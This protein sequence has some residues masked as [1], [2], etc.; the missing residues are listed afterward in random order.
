MREMIR[1][2][3][4]GKLMYSAAIERGVGWKGVLGCVVAAFGV[5]VYRSSNEP[6]YGHTA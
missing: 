3:L 4:G 2:V 5:A 6:R 1:P